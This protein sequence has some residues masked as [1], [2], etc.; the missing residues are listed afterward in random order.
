MSEKLVSIDGNTSFDLET[1]VLEMKN[2]DIVEGFVIGTNKTEI[3]L[4][5]GE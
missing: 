2:V 3:K 5:K 1:G 4:T